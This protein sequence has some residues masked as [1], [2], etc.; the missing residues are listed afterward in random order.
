MDE[1]VVSFA[2]AH[3]PCY[4]YDK[5]TVE[6][7]CR[8]LQTAL[9]CAQL[10]YSVKA[11]PYPPLV[12]AIAAQGFGADAASANE[13]LRAEAAGV[14][15]ERIF[16]SA[17][18][19]TDAELD[20]V[21]GR[22]IIIADS[23]TELAL[24]HAHA[25]RD[26]VP[27]DIGLRVHPQAGMDGR[28]AAPSK[29]GVDEAQLDALPALL[30]QLPLLRIVG[31]HVHLQSQ[32][33]DAACLAA[34]YRRCGAMTARLRD[35]YGLPLQFLNLGSGIG[36]VFDPDRQQ[37]LTLSALSAALQDVSQQLPGVQLYIETGRYLTANAGT[38]FTRV[39]D[40]KVSCG[41]TYLLV[42]NA[43]NGFLRPAV[44]ELLYRN[45]GQYPDGTQEPLYTTGA[46]CRFSL[47][48]RDG[49]TERVDIVG[50]LC[51]ATDCLAHDVLLPRAA[52]GDLLA[53]SNAGAY[54]LTLSPLA[55]SSHDAPGEYLWDAANEAFL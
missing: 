36:T 18:G 2:R 26:C 49:P 20:A 8:T 19:K 1:Q 5:A 29:F 14:A 10:L 13:V 43:L 28:S 27:A 33:L 7:R 54:G 48:G 45:L 37:P 52:R 50:T 39:V 21:W 3:A 12:R 30:A 23:L 47:P 9:P 32:L 41:K 38:Y 34:Y 22:C 24:L 6:A 4:I 25:E 40:R 46:A 15:A 44:A 53:V 17:P 42:Q 31:L 55:F 51:T 35:A 16:Y 11:N